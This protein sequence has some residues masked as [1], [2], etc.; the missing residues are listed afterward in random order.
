MAWLIILSGNVYGIYASDN[1]FLEN[2]VPYLPESY[3][4]H[5]Q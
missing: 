2:L 1:G 4:M 3:V 5:R